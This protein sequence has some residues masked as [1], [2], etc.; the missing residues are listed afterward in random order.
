MLV[1]DHYSH[2]HHGFQVRI[3]HN[4]QIGLQLLLQPIKEPLPLLFIGINVIRGIPSLGG[5]L[6]EVL[7]DTHPTLLQVEELC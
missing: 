2:I 7:S 5:E 6:V 4:H 1:L 3:R